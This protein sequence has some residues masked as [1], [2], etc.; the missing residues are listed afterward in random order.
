MQAILRCCPERR[1]L[2]AKYVCLAGDH[3]PT[4]AS[5]FSGYQN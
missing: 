5:I 1:S 4:T 3:S 2:T